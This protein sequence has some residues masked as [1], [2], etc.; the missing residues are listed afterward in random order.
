MEELKVKR[1][2]HVKGLAAK[3]GLFWYEESN[4][5]DTKQIALRR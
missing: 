4:K 3:K 1:V 5:G 2:T